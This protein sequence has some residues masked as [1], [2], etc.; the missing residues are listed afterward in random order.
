M[1]T[2]YLTSLKHTLPEV[3]A[4]LERK[5]I[6]ARHLEFGGEGKPPAKKITVPT[7]ARSEFLANRAM[8]DWAEHSLSLAL[9]QVFPD[10]KIVQYGNTDRIA[11]GHPEFKARY[12]AGI[13]E[14]RR[15][16][17]RPDLLILPGNVRA[18]E[19]ISELSHGDSDAFVN[20][21]LASIEVRSSKF[22]ALTYM[23]VRQQQREAGNKPARETPSFTVKVEDLII[24]YRWLERYGV[25][26]SYC[27]VFFDS[28]FA[29]NFLG[30]FSI[31]ASGTGFT[32][33]TPAK[34]QEKATI[35]IPITSGTM[36]GTATEPPHF[37]AEHRVT[38]LGR[39]DA[40][41][42]PCDGGFSV[43]AEAARGVL[44]P[45]V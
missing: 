33:E 32:I 37:K 21:G 3:T 22:E 10:L 20:Q 16:G 7:D 38:V 8:G 15:F 34:S 19:D 25:V 1:N 35:M 4:T 40:F 13:E 9:R 39:H 29:I 2:A 31:I 27:Q 44:L 41:V 14:T 45:V 23:R 12:L 24:V 36:I 5:G 17:K 43:D 6:E 18:P 30:I 26:Q 11:A 42:A 28:I